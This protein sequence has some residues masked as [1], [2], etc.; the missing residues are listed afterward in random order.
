[1]AP[2]GHVELTKMCYGTS[3]PIERQLTVCGVSRP[4][5]LTKVQKLLESK[6]KNEKQNENKNENSCLFSFSFFVFFHF[7]CFCFHFR[8]C[9]HFCFY[10]IFLVF[11]FKFYYDTSSFLSNLLHWKKQ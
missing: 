9:F 1:M 11:I 3:R 5:E 10:F 8:F 6:N 7:H 2:L 4:R